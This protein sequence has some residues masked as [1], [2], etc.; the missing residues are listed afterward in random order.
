MRKYLGEGAWAVDV[1]EGSRHS[2][3]TV[4]DTRDDSVVGFIDNGSEDY[5][6]WE[7]VALAIIEGRP[8]VVGPP[9][10]TR[11]QAICWRL[12]RSSTSLCTRR[13]S[14]IQTSWRGSS[15]RIRPRPGSCSV[16]GSQSALAQPSL[17]RC[18][19]RIDWIL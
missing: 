1:E 17:P 5:P 13:N 12:G 3:I 16:N 15:T 7:E 6:P 8:E 19:R 10:A 14:S 9:D 11:V 2:L 4:R 18:G